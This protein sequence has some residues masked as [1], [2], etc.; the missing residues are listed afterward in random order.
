[1]GVRSF[2]TGT[3]QKRN[4]TE[5]GIYK[6]RAESFL[7]TRRTGLAKVAFTGASAYQ[8]RIPYHAYGSDIGSFAMAYAPDFS[9]SPTSL[10]FSKDGGNLITS[11]SGQQQNTSSAA[12]GELLVELP[13][14]GVVYF[15]YTSGTGY[16]GD[17]ALDDMDIEDP[18]TSTVLH[19]ISIS[20][21][22]F[23]RSGY[24]LTQPLDHNGTW[25]VVNTSAG[26]SVQGLWNL[27]G[28][29]TPSSNTGPAVD[30]EGSV[31]GLFIFTETS[32]SQSTPNKVFSLRTTNLIS[33]YIP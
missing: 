16:A 21:S 32:G 6:G 3:G 23:E 5:S 17:F 14:D 25:Q 2:R 7:S 31:S 33:E 1:M 29:G 19:T 20:D 11:F 27:G 12:W 30:H 15:Y 10:E 4:A 9:T 24:G 22:N 28:N 13:G 26:N 18:S 8:L